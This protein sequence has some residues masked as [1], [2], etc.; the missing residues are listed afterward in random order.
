MEILITGA[1]G[2]V[3]QH[4]VKECLKRGY[5]VTCLTRP[6][7]ALPTFLKE[8]NIIFADLMDNNLSSK[9]TGKFDVIYHLAADRTFETNYYGTKNLIKSLKDNPK[10]IYMS[11]VSVSGTSFRNQKLNEETDCYPETPYAK[12]KYEAENLIKKQMKNYVILRSPRVYGP[13]DR[14][15]TFLNLVKFIRFGLLPISKIRIDLIY[16]KNLVNALLQARN[17]NR[18]TFIISDGSFSLKEISLT[19]K[20]ILKKKTYIEFK[21]TSQI[22]TIIRIISGKFEYS[23]KGITYS[24]RK[25]KSNLGYKSLYNLKEGLRE[26]IKCM[27]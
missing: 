23:S 21:I 11:S 14:Q 27:K 15:N 20:K 22:F 8:T 5:N 19:I 1:T 3:G 13:G 9:I 4:L 2:S 12:G 26:T 24:A 7:S 10:L 16:V 18:E 25:A 6:K 17:F